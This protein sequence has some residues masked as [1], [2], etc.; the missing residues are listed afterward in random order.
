MIE[1]DVAARRIHLDI[2]DDELAAR[3][4]AWTPPV[5]MFKSGFSKM[6]VDNVEGADTGADF[7]VLKGN[8]GSE[9]PRDS[10]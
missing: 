2:S 1:I 3:L 5:P 8:R 9:V 10:H 7:A 6:F 4:A